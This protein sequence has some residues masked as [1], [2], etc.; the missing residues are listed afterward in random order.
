MFKTLIFGGTTEGRVL[1]E[2]CEKNGIHV[3]VSVTTD[4]GA[5]LLQS[6]ENISILVGKLDCTQIRKLILKNKYDIVIDATHPFAVI[7]TEN[8]RNACHDTKT[9]YVRLVRESSEDIEGIV[10]QNMDE[11]VSVLNK[12]DD[13]ILSTLG[14][15][16]LLK[17]T[18]VKNYKDRLWIRILP[19][20]GITEY[21]ENMGIDKDK[22][23]LKKGPFS[24][25]ENIEHL[26]LSGAKIL[27]TKESGMIGGYSEKLQA[28]D[29]CNAV[30][31]TLKRPSENGF[32]MNE[33]Q[34]ILLEKNRRLK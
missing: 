19:A 12:S 30:T 10:V 18:S 14:S 5:E 15:K 31:V 6:S 22:I 24:V 11:L 20:D 29:I 33:V 9:S 23:I 34:R 8:I 16:E 3:D 4:Y 26:T 28:A 7:A 32:C 17:L 1:A 25:E 27:V 21:C 2:F 13:I